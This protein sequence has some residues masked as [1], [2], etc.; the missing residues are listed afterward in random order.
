VA[1]APEDIGRIL[2]Q[3]V[4]A[5]TADAVKP[6]RPPVLDGLA[7]LRYSIALSSPQDASLRHIPYTALTFEQQE[8]E[9]ATR[10]SATIPDVESNLGPLWQL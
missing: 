6:V 2:D 1:V 7:T 5:S 10:V 9:V 8:G 3:A 4:Q